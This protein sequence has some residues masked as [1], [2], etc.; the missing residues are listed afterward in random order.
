MKKKIRAKILITGYEDPVK[1]RICDIG[2][3]GTDEEIIAI[4]LRCAVD[5]CRRD[6]QMSDNQI[7]GLFTGCVE[8]DR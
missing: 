6:L 1:G 4:L 8:H 2:Y 3:D 7:I 5:I